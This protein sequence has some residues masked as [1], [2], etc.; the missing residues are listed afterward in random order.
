MEHHEKRLKKNYY[1]FYAVVAGS[2]TPITAL[3]AMSFAL[4]SLCFAGKGFAYIS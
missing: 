3:M 1:T 4:F 2:L